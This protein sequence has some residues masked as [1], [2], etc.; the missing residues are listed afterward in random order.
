MRPLLCLTLAWSLVAAERPVPPPGVPV[1]P[2]DKADLEGGLARLSAS[3]DRIKD[4]LL[5]PDVIVYRD[6]VRFALTYNEFFKVEEIARAK[7]L[8]RQGQ[9]RADA[10]SRGQAPW[11]TATGLVVRGY[12]SR[13]DDS[14]Q[15]YGLVIPESWNPKSPKKHR[16]DA[17]FHGRGE[18]L[19][20]VNFIV[21]RQ[22]RPGEFTPPDTFVLHLYGRYCNANKF[23]GEVD[24]FEA[25][26]EVRR[27]Y[28]IDHNRLVMRGFS[29]GG[30]AAWQFG[31]HFAGQWA[32][33][34][35]GA[36]FSE[37]AEFLKVF[38]NEAVKPTAWEQKLWRM[39]DAT[40]YA[41]NF[42]NTP[43]VAYSGEID[44]QKQAADIMA[45][46]LAKE[47]ITMTHIIGPNT[48]HRYHPDSKV[49]INRR[50]DAIAEK[51]RDPYP[52]TLKFTTYTLQYNR[53]KWLVLDGLAQHWEKA[54][55]KADVASDQQVNVATQNVTALT[56]DF[57]PGGCPLAADSK[58]RVVIDGQSITVHGPESDRSWRAHFRKNG[59]QWTK[60]DSARGGELQKRHGLQG[61]IDHAFMQRFLIVLPTGEAAI[62]GPAERI[63]AE[64]ARSITEWRR[65]FRGDARVKKD[66]EVTDAD[67]ADSNLIL[68]GDPGSNKVLARVADKL[69]VQWSAAG[70]KVG[71][72]SYSAGEHYPA[73]IYPNPLNPNHYIVVNSS[74]TYREYDYLNNARQVSKLPDWAI[75]DV[76]QPADGRWPGRI[77]NAGFFSERWQLQ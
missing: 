34:A 16:L 73:L 22:T 45:K 40:E 72:Q 48:P 2:N 32:A 35:P 25:L 15:P 1:P 28:N 69:P 4:N 33:V 6:A 56:L 46:Y 27:H 41:L 57:G 66:T 60:V 68:W 8:L 31:A 51:G 77:A 44:R 14:V 47:G 11:T 76:T 39:Y 3:I 10:L 7:E 5:A 13:I 64:Q 67:I 63:A 38:Q 43:L 70:I 24:L 20:E 19:S 50:I 58:P 30:A 18:T 55:V 59:T 49:E 21:E 65:Q 23:A 9:E 42:F 12:R 62:K 71:G 53:M 54:I 29:M 17:W 52:R 36:G 26:R 74:F 61:P 37:T 75:V